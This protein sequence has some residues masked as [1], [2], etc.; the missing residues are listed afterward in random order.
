[1]NI[2][3]HSSRFDRFV[4]V[5]VVLLLALIFA[6]G[7]YIISR[8]VGPDVPDC[9][10]TDR[11]NIIDK[12]NNMVYLDWYSEYPMIGLPNDPIMV[13]YD[14]VEIG[15]DFENSKILSFRFIT[16]RGYSE[17]MVYQEYGL[18]VDGKAFMSPN[19]PT[20]EFKS[21]V[22]KI[23]NDFIS[24][25]QTEENKLGDGLFNQELQIY[26]QTIMSILQGA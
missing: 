13:E 26:S 25:K 3:S 1:M 7:G 22:D 4:K 8:L 24:L 16:K 21:T 2:F 11:D 20:E 23:A 18:T 15:Y 12:E 9:S 6:I 19:E 14:Y 10:D 17:Y 5:A